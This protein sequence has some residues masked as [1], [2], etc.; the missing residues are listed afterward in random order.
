[1]Y[2]P[3]SKKDF[4]ASLDNQTPVEKNT[5]KNT[6]SK[7]SANA[8]IY[9]RIKRGENLNSIA[10]KYGVTVSEIKEWNN[11]R[12]NKIL[13]GTRLK[14]LSDKTTNYLV[15]NENAKTLKKASLY[16]HKIKT[17]ETIGEIA[18]KFGVTTTQIRRWNGLA[19]NKL[20]AGKTL[21]IYSS[22]NSSSLG[23][24]TTK[25]PAT[26]NYYKVKSGDTI[27][28]IAELYKV[29][30]ASIVKWNDIRGNKIYSGQKLKIYSDYSVNDIQTKTNRNKTN[31]AKIHTVRKGETLFSIATNYNLSVVKLK[32]INRFSDNKI[33]VGQKIRLE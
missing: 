15:S 5:I 17:G 20:Y 1:M 7:K 25:T 8:W 18:Q 32:S 22:D 13:L 27:G 14:V 23:D 4:Y 30:S 16:K 12:S 3:E 11:L 29:S 24:V 33:V 6:F 19:S 26:I 10:S 9:H 2:V 28:K 31:T 21:K